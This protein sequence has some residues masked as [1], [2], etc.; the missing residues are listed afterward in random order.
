M[1][2]DANWLELVALVARDELLVAN[3]LR[4]HHASRLGHCAGCGTRTP[5]M[6]PC[7][8][9]RLAVAANGIVQA[10]DEAARAVAAPIRAV[11]GQR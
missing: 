5:T 1:N 8:L 7:T 11:R 3:L 6:W 9:R 10:N 2:T 4:N